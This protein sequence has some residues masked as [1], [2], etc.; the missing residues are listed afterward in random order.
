MLAIAT[1]RLIVTGPNLWGF[2]RIQTLRR[3][4]TR[5]N[6][7]YPALHGN[8]WNIGIRAGGIPPSERWRR[9]WRLI[10]PNRAPNVTASAT[11]WTSFG[12]RHCRPPPSLQSLINQLIPLNPLSGYHLLSATSKISAV[13][14]CS[15]DDSFATSNPS[16]GQCNDPSLQN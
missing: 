5:T 9:R 13:A 16:N 15:V 14:H 1:P 11:T 3:G 12:H 7:W 6:D 8:V 10:R 4:S 2:P